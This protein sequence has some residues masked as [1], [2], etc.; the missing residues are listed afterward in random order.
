MGHV[1]SD[2]YLSLLL[3]PLVIGRA[4]QDWLLGGFDAGGAVFA[5]RGPALCPKKRSAS[6]SELDEKK[7][8]AQPDVGRE[9]RTRGK[10]DHKVDRSK[11]ERPG[12]FLDRA[13]QA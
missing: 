13:M 11:Q 12:P 9:V 7:H 4:L 5:R 6:V 8:Q 2:F 1:N 3:V 10:I